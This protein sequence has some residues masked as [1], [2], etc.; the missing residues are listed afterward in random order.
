MN[1]IA[2]SEVKGKQNWQHGNSRS[3]RQQRPVRRELTL[4]EPQAQGQSEFVMTVDSETGQ[5]QW[6]ADIRR[7]ESIR[8]AGYADQAFQ[9]FE[10]ELDKVL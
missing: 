2:L 4:E 6:S 10:F 8:Q 9:R 1:E 7:I 5:E 3:C